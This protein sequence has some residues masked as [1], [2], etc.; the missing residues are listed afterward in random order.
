M[1]EFDSLQLTVSARAT[2]EHFV[3]LHMYAI[4]SLIVLNT[5]FRSQLFPAKTDARILG[6]LTLFTINGAQC[7]GTAAPTIS[8]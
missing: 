1:E 3:P 5:H 4:A 6:A 7:E 8:S 2:A